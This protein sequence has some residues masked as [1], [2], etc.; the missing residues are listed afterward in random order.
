MLAHKN[1][2]HIP[3][4]IPFYQQPNKHLFDKKMLTLF[5]VSFSNSEL[6]RRYSDL[7]EILKAYHQK[8]EPYLTLGIT[9]PY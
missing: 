3:L 7:L 4:N 9:T 5:V 2:L 6:V 8:A 1:T